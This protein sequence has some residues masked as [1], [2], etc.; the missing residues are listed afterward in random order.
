MVENL[1]A[2]YLGGLT[3]TGLDDA[4]IIAIRILSSSGH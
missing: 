2:Q 3:A 4:G 1:N